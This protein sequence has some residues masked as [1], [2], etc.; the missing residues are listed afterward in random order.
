MKFDFTQDDP[1]VGRY[2]SFEAAAAA[3]VAGSATSTAA[4]TAGLAAS[5]AGVGAVAGGL[6]NV[7]L[8]A[9]APSIFSFSNVLTAFSGI[10]QLAGG[11]I[12]GQQLDAQS[13]LEGLRAQ[14]D[15]LEGQ[16]LVIN[17]KEQLILDLSAAD[18]ARAGAGVSASTGSPAA[19]KRAA[20]ADLNFQT[21]I[22]RTGAA[23]RA[24]T[25]RSNASSLRSQA[26]AARLSGL[27]G[28]IA[29]GAEIADRNQRRGS[30]A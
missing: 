9:A 14:S 12:Q 21:D 5:T 11:I 25:R 24:A 8:T 27:A 19:A 4:A 1:A 13:E 30:L 6:T 18:A 15:L 20:I 3:L 17:Q 16:R 23:I 29:S 22:T 28:A 10:S 26:G 2:C 7:A